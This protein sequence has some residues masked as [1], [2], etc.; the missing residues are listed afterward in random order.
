MSENKSNFMIQQLIEVNAAVA[1]IRDLDILLES[2]LTKAREI[3]NADAGS[4]YIR[5]KS[6]LH[7]RVAQNDTLSKNLP[8]GK[9]LA[10]ST[11]TVDIDNSTISGYV[12]NTGK[13]LKIDNVYELSEEVPYKFGKKYDELSN[14]RTQ[15]MLTI[16]LKTI[17]SHIVG[18][19]QIINAKDSEGNIIPFD[20]DIMPIIDFFA[21]SAAI[22]IERALMTRE[23]ILRMI[24]MAELRDPKETGAHVNRVGAYS[25]EIYDVWALKKNIPV[26]ELQYNRDVLRIAA[27]LHDVGK[28][29]ISDLILKKNARFTT[30]EFEA[31][32]LHT[33]YGAR[34]FD[35]YNSD[36]DAA[37]SSI[38]LCHHERWDGSGYPGWI[39]IH[40]CEPLNGK[41]NTEGKP[42]GRREE[43]IPL[44]ARIVAIADVY[45]ALSSARIYKEA[46]SE[47]DVLD[48]LEKNSGTQFEPELISC[49]FTSLDT[50]KSLAERYK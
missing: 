48:N 21:N 23:L 17:H 6:N 44:Y 13:I 20:E 39:D 32:K 22:S 2:I 36:I 46:W 10:Y 16:P 41:R 12:A 5:D 26:H 15:S 25:V 45:D 19:L 27:M 4:I 29:G 18:V 34:L 42:I 30:E 24:K 40:T 1:N 33:I 49:F 35:E 47:Q 37:A 43:E 31:M 28:V 7:F 3:S 38:A 8:K 11:F 50:I 9:K 14:Y